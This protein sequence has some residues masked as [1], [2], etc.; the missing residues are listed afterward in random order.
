MDQAQ[1]ALSPVDFLVFQIGD[2]E[3]CIDVKSQISK[4]FS[5]SA[6]AKIAEVPDF[7]LGTFDLRGTKV[8]AFDLRLILG[9]P[10]P[11]YDNSA[12]V[13]VAALRNRTISMVVDRVSDFARGVFATANAAWQ[14]NAM[15]LVDKRMI[16]YIDP[17]ILIGYGNIDRTFAA[18]SEQR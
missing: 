1:N 3:Y 4:I 15:V 17:G 7:V 9:S 6:P 10:N 12:V 18:L 2:K 5:Y 16:T 13:I 8:A 14:H 11:K